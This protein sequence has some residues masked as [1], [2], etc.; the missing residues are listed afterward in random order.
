MLRGEPT[1]TIP[2][3]G[4][5][6]PDDLQPLSLTTSKQLGRNSGG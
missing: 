3:A 1:S 2:P 5:G 4:K 6:Q